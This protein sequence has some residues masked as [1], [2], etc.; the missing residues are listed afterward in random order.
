MRVLLK[1]GRVVDPSQNLDGTYDVLIEGNRVV[2]VEKKIDRVEATKVID[3]SGLIVSPGFIDLHTHLREPG[4]EWKEDIETGSQAAVA[5]GFTS[6]C[7]MANTD[8][9]NDNPSVTKYIVDRGKEVGLCDVFPIG[10]ITKGL[11]G[12]ELAEIGLMVKAGIVAISDD[13][14][15]PRDSRVLRNAMDYAR[16]LGIPVFTHSE[17]K[18]LSAGGHMNEGPLSTRLGIPGMPPEAEDIGTMRD[19]LIAKLTGA[20]IHVCHVSSKGALKIIEEAKGDGVRVT[21]EITPHHFTLTEDAVEG[22]NTNAKMCPPLR[23]KD[24]VEACRIALKKGVADS[25][26]TDHAPHSE[27]EKLVE[28]CR[29]P[30]GIIGL[31]TALPL[32]LNL[33]REGYLTLS[34]MIEK[35]STN[36]SRIIG[37]RDIGSLKP[38]SRANVTVFDPEEEFVLTKEEIKSKSC[39]T[40]FLNKRLRGRVKITIYNGKIVFKDK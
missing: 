23:T 27:D 16:S 24:H 34:Q 20:H 4:Q 33:V 22:F 19:I 7:C 18:T 36:P 21:C 30:F 29:A 40:P 5:G 25:I 12:E 35:L 26:A 17:D 8:P 11:K 10:A 9:V 38:G 31:Q 15:S 13:G 37:K 32:S 1:G 14:E 28:F 6:V 3:V 2:K 39:N